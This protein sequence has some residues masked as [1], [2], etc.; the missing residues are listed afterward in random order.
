MLEKTM[1]HGKM[2]L[3]DLMMQSGEYRLLENRIIFV[4]EGINASVSKRIVSNLLAMEAAKP[5]S[6]ITMYL[7][8]PGGEVNSGYAIFDTIRF[9]T[10]PVNIVASGL[11]ASIA[12]VIF[13]ATEK[14]RRYTMPNTKFLIHQP[15]IPGQ[16]Y[17]Q[18]SDIEIT[19]KEILKTRQKIND[20]LSKEC[21]QPLEKVAKDTT[22]D[23][24]MSASE[25]LEYGL[26]TKIIENIKELK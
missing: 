15:L 22:R 3:S 16:I 23:Y 17:G 4:S 6:P 20:L 18:A 5:G 1:E 9:I 10:S 26:V 25:A 14:N 8:S 11:C 24:W 19:A 12:T 13:V 21:K 2:E 7:N